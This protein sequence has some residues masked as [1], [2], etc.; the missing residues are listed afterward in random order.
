M[1]T[2]YTHVHVHVYMYTC[3]YIT[4]LVL[5]NNYMYIDSKQIYCDNTFTG[6]MDLGSIV[7]PL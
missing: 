7:F 6:S 4:I 2:L 1:I 5:G 3:T